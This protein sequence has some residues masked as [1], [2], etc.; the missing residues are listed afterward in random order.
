L[1]DALDAIVK[2]YKNGLARFLAL[3]YLENEEMLMTCVGELMEVRTP[4]TAIRP[5]VL[6][7]IPQRS[8][9]PNV[10][11]SSKISTKYSSLST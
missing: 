1:K 7:F 2:N 4:F 5:L 11:K 8:A 10:A 9:K 3:P 6:I